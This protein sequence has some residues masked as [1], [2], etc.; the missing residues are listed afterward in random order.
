MTDPQRECRRCRLAD[1]RTQVVV[2]RGNPQATVMMVGEAPGRDEDRTGYGFQ[3]AAGKIFDQVLEYLGLSRDTIWLANAVRCRPTDDGR[4]NRPPLPDE[5]IAC[6]P[7]LMDDVR[8]VNPQ[9][10]VT[11]GRTAWESLTGGSWK[12][13]TAGAPFPLAESRWAVALYHPAYLIYRRAFWPQYRDHLDRLAAFLREM[14]VSTDPASGP[15]LTMVR[16]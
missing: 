12:D 13:V 6:R 15:F 3:G 14:G 7:W 16:E 8:T 10:I 2:G 4:K 5:V 9:V 11:F 1:R